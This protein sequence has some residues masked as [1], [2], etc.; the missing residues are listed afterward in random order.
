MSLIP[1]IACNVLEPILG[2]QK[3]KKEL[4]L[5]KHEL[6]LKA[7][8]HT[9]EIDSHI[10]I[11]LKKL[12]SAM[13]VFDDIINMAKN[14]IEARHVEIMHLL[15]LRATIIQLLA[16]SVLGSDQ[17]DSLQN[18]LEQIHS[19]IPIMIKS[20]E[21]MANEVINNITL[22]DNYRNSAR[23][24]S[25]NMHEYGEAGDERFHKLIEVGSS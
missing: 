16:S 14:I 2:Y 7:R 18:T 20:S 4:K 23:I 12:E 19:E 17:I 9:M 24:D 11:E 25:G 8:V 10:K 5:K 1:S 15:D 22:H 21:Y 6:E 13:R 3:M